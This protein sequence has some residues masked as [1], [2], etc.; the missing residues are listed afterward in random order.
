MQ[1]RERADRELLDAG[2]VVGHLVPAIVEATGILRGRHRRAVDSTILADA[3]AT[4]DT[5]TQL[6]SQIRR[7]IRVVPA[8]AEQIAQ[9]CTTSTQGRTNW[10]RPRDVLLRQARGPNRDTTT[11]ARPSRPLAVAAGTSARPAS[12]WR[13]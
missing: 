10:L 5:V 11:L 3:V 12:A 8:A 1:G 13:P 2:A 6:I 7:V 4:Q 9:R